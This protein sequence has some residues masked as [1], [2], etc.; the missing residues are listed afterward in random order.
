MVFSQAG[1]FFHS[2][3]FVCLLFAFVN[4]SRLPIR[5]LDVPSPNSVW[6]CVAYIISPQD[7]HRHNHTKQNT[8]KQR[9]HENPH[10]THV[11]C[12]VLC[13]EEA[14]PISL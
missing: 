11:R 12:E 4:T 6:F 9:I 8:G 14:L 5:L 1:F 10:S 13:H 2:E 3:F 7:T